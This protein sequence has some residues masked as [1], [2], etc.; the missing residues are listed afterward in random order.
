MLN[1]I[2]KGKENTKTGHKEIILQIASRYMRDNPQKPYI[3]R[4]YNVNG[5]K[6]D[7]DGRYIIDFNEKYG[8]KAR[9]N[10]YGYAISKLYADREKIVNISISLKGPAWIYL[11]GKLVA[12]T[13]SWD[14]AFDRN[15][16]VNLELKK[17]E[18]ILFVK[19]RKNP[20]GFGCIIGTDN[21][22]N[23]MY[24]FYSAAD[25]S[26]D[27]IGWNYSDIYESDVLSA[28]DDFKNIGW[29]P[30][31][32]EYVFKNR[33]VTYA[34]TGILCDK[35]SEVQID[36]KT[37]NKYDLYIDGEIIKADK[38]KLSCGLHNIAAKIYNTSENTKFRCEFIGAK[39]CL[40][41]NIL[42]VKSK[43]LY[44]ETDDERAQ[45]GFDGCIVY[46]ED[47]YY[48]TA[49]DTYLRPVLEADLFGK[50]T[51]PLGVV[52]YGILLAGRAVGSQ[53]MIDYAHSHLLNTSKI[54]DYAMW[55]TA[56]YGYAFVNNNMLNMD[57]LDDCGSYGSAVLEDYLKYNNEQCFLDLTR[58]IA[59][60]ILG[61]QERL[62]NGMFYRR[63]EGGY[64]QD[65]IWAD[66]IYMS[67]PFMIRY[68][69]LV[70]DEKVL[71]DVINQFICF[72]DMLY[73]PKKKLM[74]HIYSLKY[75][76]PSNIPWGRGNGWVLFSLSELLMVLKKDNK[77]YRE[78][79]EFFM[80]LC[81]GFYEVLDS[82]G[83][84]HQ[85]LDEPNSYAE[86]SCSAMC[87]ASYARGVKLGIL[88]DK[89]LA[90]ARKTVKALEE[91]CVDDDGNVYGVCIGSGYS[92]RREYYTQELPW[93]INDTHGTGIV[94]IA[95]AEV[96]E[97]EDKGE[98]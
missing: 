30:R 8:A 17:G 45:N 54:H 2:A 84:L 36:F 74:S 78:V 49:K 87:A 26:E 67:T 77:H 50:S 21:P 52:L 11:N 91:M 98:K 81:E 79:E 65:T 4:P 89:Y 38:L 19:C 9:E 96:F 14:E 40:P 46:D 13:H 94:M 63:Q 12:Q 43:W 3:Y 85:V 57:A 25:G 51:Y 58:Y 24:C 95:I 75:N 62:S 44:L 1:Y 60:Y 71:E 61:K 15:R 53:E 86:A 70:K 32:E 7:K 47:A 80:S 55:D 22:K 56:R 27:M 20:L 10:D 34:I 93:H 42:G 33:A 68:A 31:Q 64:Y 92:F 83:M 97:L 48:I 5:F 69:L 72:K 16:G 76:I 35:E 23:N 37:G 28:G 18:N 66:D 88:E 6:T 73:M 29:Y 90:A 39:Q 41:E 82:D 59:E